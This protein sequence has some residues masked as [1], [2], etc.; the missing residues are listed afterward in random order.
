LDDSDAIYLIKN[1]IPQKGN[2]RSSYD[3]T[4]Q[5]GSETKN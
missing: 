5:N 1:N 3:C 2:D 4:P